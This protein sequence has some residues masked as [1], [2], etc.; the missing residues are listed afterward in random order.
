M[1]LGIPYKDVTGKY[2]FNTRFEFARRNSY[3]I[4]DWAIV[5]G[6]FEVL[7][8]DNP[9]ITFNIPSPAYFKQTKA[10]SN[11]QKWGLKN[12]DAAGYIDLIYQNNP[13]VFTTN[14][15]YNQPLTDHFR[16]QANVE[17]PL[18]EK[19][20]LRLGYSP[21]ELK[22]RDCT[23]KLY[24][25]KEEIDNVK[26]ITGGVKYGCLMFG[27]RLENLKGRWEFDNHLFEAA[28]K[29]SN[30]PIFYYSEFPLEGTN[31][32]EL[33]QNKTNIENL[34]LREQLTLKYLADF[35]L[36]YHAGINDAILGNGKDNT[37]LTPYTN[38][39]ETHIRNTRYIFPNGET[40]FLDYDIT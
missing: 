35:N 2:E 9:N 16:A 28:K 15:F 12:H 23:P 33:F 8:Q 38:W 10:P 13:N 19:I 11:Y 32:G 26:K 25:T 1:R 34:S 40:K 27:S 7:K 37:I 30:Y 6:I 36:G 17:I 29:Y 14:G 22:Y 21:D 18:A 24:L 39:R 3:S 5:S 31:W 4:G 20:L